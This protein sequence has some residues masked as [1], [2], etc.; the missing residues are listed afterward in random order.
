MHTYLTHI[1]LTHLTHRYSDQDGKMRM[2]LSFLNS[3]K[4]WTLEVFL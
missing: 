2:D 1:R 4:K 3:L